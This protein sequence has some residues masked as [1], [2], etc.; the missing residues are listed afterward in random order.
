MAICP[1]CREEMWTADGCSAD[2]V[3]IVDRIYRRTI[4]TFADP[5]ERCPGC[6]AM[7][8]S[9]HHLGCDD[10]RCPACL[11]QLIS[12]AC[13]L[14]DEWTSDLAPVW[15]DQRPAWLHTRS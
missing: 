4:T 15:I 10:E 9:V 13:P 12:C 14:V 8:G 7:W 1:D 3:R 6:G 5:G 11:G 2:G